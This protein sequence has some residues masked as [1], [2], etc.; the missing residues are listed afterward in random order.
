[1][2]HS[3]PSELNLGHDH[4]VLAPY[5][6]LCETKVLDVFQIYIF[7]VTLLELQKLLEQSAERETSEKHSRVLKDS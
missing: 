6:K 5:S 2:E 4:Q 1:M 3:Y 7:Y